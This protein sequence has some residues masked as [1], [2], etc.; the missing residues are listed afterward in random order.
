MKSM[1]QEAIEA[2]KKFNEILAH[3][4]FTLETLEKL[5]VKVD[6][7]ALEKTME[8]AFKGTTINT[9]GNC[10]ITYFLVSKHFY[11]SLSNECIVLYKAKKGMEIT[12]AEEA[13]DDSADGNGTEAI[14]NFYKE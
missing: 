9:G 11:V 1:K 8:E 5:G 12:T 6:Y 3:R 10:M 2:K 7:E 13:C 14:A 4:Q